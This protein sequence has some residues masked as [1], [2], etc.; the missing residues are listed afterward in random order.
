MQSRWLLSHSSSPDLTKDLQL[1]SGVIG[2]DMVRL[3][4]RKRK[5]VRYGTV[6]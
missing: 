6:A 1:W 4:E 5:G 3:Y 2:S